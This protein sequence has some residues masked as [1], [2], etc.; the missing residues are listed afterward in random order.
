MKTS[1]LFLNSIAFLL[2]V[3]I[4]EAPTNRLLEQNHA[5]STISQSK[6]IESFNN[7]LVP[8]D[9]VASLS[10]KEDTQAIANESMPISIDLSYLKFDVT[11]FI[12]AENTSVE[13]ITTM[14]AIPL[15]DMSYL[16]FDVNNFISNSD[17][18]SEELISEPS[19]L[20]PT[21]TQIIELKY[22]KFDVNKFVSKSEIEL[23]EL[24]I[25]EVN[26]P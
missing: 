11:N 9:N 12:E 21:L 22:L 17:Q 1:I 14:E 18:S 24:P 23:I 8:A 15:A 2:M 13:E 16:M 6:A 25:S 4:G 3:T 20:D 5:K 19:T 26:Q 7:D 10:V